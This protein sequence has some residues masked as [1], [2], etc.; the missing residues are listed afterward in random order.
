MSS[1]ALVEKH[2]ETVYETAPPGSV[3]TS[4]FIG[5]IVSLQVLQGYPFLVL[6][7]LSKNEFC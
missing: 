6:P 4:R 7:R 3:V 5:I 2:Y 1:V